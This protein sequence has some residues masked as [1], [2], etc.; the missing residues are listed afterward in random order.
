MSQKQPESSSGPNGHEMNDVCAEIAVQYSPLSQHAHSLLSPLVV[1]AFPTKK[2]SDRHEKGKEILYCN[3]GDIVT[4][5]IQC[6][7]F[8]FTCSPEGPDPPLKPLVP[9]SP[10]APFMPC[11]PRGPG[12][13]SAP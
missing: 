1:L 9:S 8:F 12:S 13:P 4:L 11:C 5:E 10:F 6:F 2:Y 7:F 3:Y